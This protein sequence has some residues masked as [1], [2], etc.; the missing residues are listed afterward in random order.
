MHY[1]HA[2]ISN[3]LS[4]KQNKMSCF[5]WSLNTGLTALDVIGFI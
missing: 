5:I 2:A 4:E 1:F 3:H